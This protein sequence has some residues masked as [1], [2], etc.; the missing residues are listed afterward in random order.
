LDFS[1]N[2]QNSL[3]NAFAASVFITFQV[4]F[5][6]TEEPEVTWRNSDCM[7]DV[8]FL[9]VLISEFPSSSVLNCDTKHCPY[10]K[11]SFWNLLQMLFNNF[12]SIYG[13]QH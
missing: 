11:S 12:V 8:G 1:Q 2:C 10:A 5:N 9:R 7:V 4:L 3:Q 6:E 13:K